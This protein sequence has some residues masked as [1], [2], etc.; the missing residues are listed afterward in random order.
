MAERID[1]ECGVQPLDRIL[2]ERGVEN[3][4]LVE[5]SGE[6]LTHKVVQKGR[7]GRRLTPNSQGKIVRVLNRVSPNEPPWRAADLFT[8]ADDPRPR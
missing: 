3:H 5:A 8:Y 2:R 6:G 4:A 7:K 1:M